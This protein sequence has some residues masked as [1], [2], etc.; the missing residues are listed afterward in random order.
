MHASRRA[1]ITWS[2]LLCL[3]QKPILDANAPPQ[4]NKGLEEEEE[5]KKTKKRGG[6]V[7]RLS[8]RWTHTCTV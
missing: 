1:S 5:E 3:T 6:N 2:G 7:W 8:D 4:V